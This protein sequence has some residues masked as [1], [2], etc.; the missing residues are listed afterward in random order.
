MHGW[1]AVPLWMWAP[2]K[3]PRKKAKPGHFGTGF[4]RHLSAMR[5]AVSTNLTNLSDSF[6]RA[7]LRYQLAT[8]RGALD[9]AQDAL[10][11]AM[12]AT[13][14]AVVKDALRTCALDLERNG[15]R[16]ANIAKYLGAL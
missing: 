1:K 7:E 16:V 6:N 3:R 10:R 5:R 15:K 13:D 2:K 4:A 8:A 12:R 9:K 11:M 14:A